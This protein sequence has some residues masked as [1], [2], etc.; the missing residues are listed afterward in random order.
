MLRT[1]PGRWDVEQATAAGWE[2]GLMALILN[3]RLDHPA[4]YAAWSPVRGGMH[5]GPPRYFPLIVDK[6]V[7][8]GALFEL[9]WK[10]LRGPLP[11]YIREQILASVARTVKES[12]S[13]TPEALLRAILNGSA[14]E[15]LKQLAAC[16]ICSWKS[17]AARETVFRVLTDSNFSVGCKQKALDGMRSY[18][19]PYAWDL[20]R[21]TFN[22][23]GENTNLMFGYHAVAALTNSAARELLRATVL[24][25]QA[26]ASARESALSALI[27][28]DESSLT[29]NVETL[30]VILQDSKCPAEVKIKAFDLY[31]RDHRREV[32]ETMDFGWFRP[33]YLRFYLRTVVEDMAKERNPGRDVVNFN[34][35]GPEELRFVQ[36]LSSRTNLSPELRK[37]LQE[38]ADTIAKQLK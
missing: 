36:G 21:E 18:T 29:E 22:V 19:P 31:P 26:S 4:E 2:P 24:N 35:T 30:R 3:S 11:D 38:V 34:G 13:R 23:W 28:H 25:A 10:G 17:E 5:Y 27:H 20:L 1:H 15:D 8:E 33:D 12:G 37:V 6:E 32:F 16:F 14:E 7:E 9:L